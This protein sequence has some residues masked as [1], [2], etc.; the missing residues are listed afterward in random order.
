MNEEIKQLIKTTPDDAELGRKIR[1]L[2]NILYGNNQNIF[3]PGYISTTSQEGQTK[4]D[5]Q[6]LKG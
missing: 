5:K 3:G 2:Y 1:G 4:K 6:L